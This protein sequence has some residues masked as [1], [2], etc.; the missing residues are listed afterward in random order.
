GKTNDGT[1]ASEG[2]KNLSESGLSICSDAMLRVTG[3]DRS[4]RHFS[5]YFSFASFSCPQRGQ[6]RTPIADSGFRLAVD[7]MTS[8]DRAAGLLMPDCEFFFPAGA[9]ETRLAMPRTNRY[10]NRP[11]INSSPDFSF[12]SVMRFPLMCVSQAVSKARTTR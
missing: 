11:T 8:L 2:M 9:S 3:T 6:I 5:Q 1:S 7:L 4:L 10:L 12:P